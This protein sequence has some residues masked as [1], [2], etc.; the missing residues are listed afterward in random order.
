MKNKNYW[1]E[2]YSSENNLTHLNKESNFAKFV[3]DFLKKKI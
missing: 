1:D 2:Y 3:F